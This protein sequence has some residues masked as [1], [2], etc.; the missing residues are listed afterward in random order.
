MSPELLSR[1][2]KYEVVREIARGSMGIVCL[3]YDPFIDR[4]VAIKVAHAG[5][6]RDPES[7][8][9]YRRMF[10]N[11][12]HTAGLLAHPNIV[13][14]HDAGV[15][16]ETCYIV[17]EYVEGER[18]LK[19]Y[20]RPQQL[21]PVEQAVEMLYKCARALDYAH[22]QGVI[23]RDIKPTNILVTRDL[24]VKIGDFSIACI[25]KLDATAT[26]PAGMVGSPRYMS[27]EQVSE[28]YLTHQTDL[29]SLGVIAYELLSG[30][31]PFQA[32]N[33]SR[34]VGKILHESPPPLC[35]LRP[36]LPAALEAAVDRALAKDRQARYQS[37]MEFARAL[38]G[39]YGELAELPRQDISAEE[40]FLAVRELAFFGEFPEAE[41]WEIVRAGSWQ[42]YEDAQAIVA[43]GELD[44]CFFLLCAGEVSVH[45]AGQRLRTL[46]RGECFGE[47]GYVGRSRRTATL[48]AQGQAALLKLDAAAIGQ[49]SVNC[50]VR[51]LKMFLR[52]IIHRLSRVEQKS[53]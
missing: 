40:K 41:V 17:M 29:F 38:A 25:K 8:R 45:K 4:Q 32:D 34:L 7:G 24:D 33:F 36:E 31:H 50:Q 22:R 35:G 37:G 19:H 21:P 42:V 28:D 26:L 1:L 49:V 11:E 53:A 15:D 12:A 9:E 44:D 46:G 51:F 5:Q 18:T 20:T 2:G 14:I 6:L 43:E 3:G 10:F 30:R 23:H 48:V 47:M 27:P 39:V 16:A 13:A 52:T